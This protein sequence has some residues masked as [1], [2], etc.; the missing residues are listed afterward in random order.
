MNYIDQLPQ[1]WREHWEA[2]GFTAPS[3]IQ[4]QSFMP[5]TAGENVMGVSPTGSGKTLAYL[6]PL[7][8]QVKPA[9]GNQLLILASSQELAMQVSKVATEWAGLIG[10]KAQALI[11]GASLKRQTEKL[12]EKP[13]VLIGTP[14]RIVELIKSKKIKNHQL[15]TIVMDEADQLF[16]D[17]G[18]NLTKTILK[19]APVDYQL[20]FFSATADRVLEQARAFAKDQ[21]TLIDVTATDQSKGEVQH[22]YLETPIRKRVDQLRRLAYIPNFKGI[23]F[24]NQMSDL[25]AAEEKLLYEGVPVISLAS[26]QNKTLRKLAI[27]RF[28]SGQS[29]M[30]LTTDIAARGLDFTEVP[31]V[32]NFEM[33]LR[34]ESYIHRAGRVGRMGA[35]GEVITLVQ[36]DKKEYLKTVRNSGF[37]AQAIYLYGG[38]L[39]TEPAETVDSVSKAADAHNKQK[40]SKPSLHAKKIKK[41]NKN[42]GARRK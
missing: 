10:L 31:Y 4:E 9:G 32:I 29:S 11:G 24:F 40:K 13:E 25:G 28:E 3:L 33:P 35:K 21:L 8:L 36:G 5:L 19:S 22:Y 17:N 26:D 41:N 37:S 38:E 2:K 15:T 39:H 16:Q 20:V 34:T 42:K 6:L 14:G 23:V 7:L 27:D 18:V 1:V 12:K 30:L